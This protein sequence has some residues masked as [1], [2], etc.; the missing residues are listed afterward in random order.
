MVRAA[1]PL[2]TYRFVN[3]PFFPR[4]HPAV[5]VGDEGIKPNESK[6]K[7]IVTNPCDPDC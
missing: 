2:L 4:S 7:T 1:P 6:P 3:Q 5:A